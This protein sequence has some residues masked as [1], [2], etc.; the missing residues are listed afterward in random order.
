[1]IT[2]QHIKKS[3]KLGSNEL[4]VLKD[5]NLEIQLGTLTY[6]VGESGSGKSTLLNIIGGIDTYDS[7]TYYF[8]NEDIST[9]S[10][11]DLTY[12]RREKVGF[13]FQNFNLISHLSSIENVELSMVLNDAAD[14]KKRALELLKLVGMDSYANHLPNQLS[15]GQ[16]Q[17][18]AIARALANNPDVILADEPTGAPDSENSIQVMEILR[19]IADQGKTVI[20]V[21]HSTELLHYGDVVIRIKDGEIINEHVSNN[22]TNHLSLADKRLKNRRKKIGYRMSFK[23]ASRNINS[24]KWC[25]F[26]TAFAAAIGIIGILIISALSNGINDKIDSILNHDVQLESLNVSNQN[27]SPLTAN[28]LKK[29]NTINGIKDT[30]SYNAYTVNIIT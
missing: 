25:N 28:D 19:N 13:V 22:A 23:L 17:R 29:V 26:I 20:V 30:L 9:Y 10:E 15:G 1:M 7:G 27:N 16:K 8:E 21:T 24:K 12:F 4:Q 3:Y 6:L 18:V 11:K 14:S 2:L 5:I